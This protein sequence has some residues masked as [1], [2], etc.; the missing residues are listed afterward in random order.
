M[1]IIK[2][3]KEGDNNPVTPMCP[4]SFSNCP[5]LTVIFYLCLPAF[6]WEMKVK[7][8]RTKRTKMLQGLASRKNW[9]AS[10][11]APFRYS[12]L[13]FLSPRLLPT[14]C[15]GP[16][17]CLP[18][19]PQRKWSLYFFPASKQGNGNS[20]ECTDLLQQVC[21]TSENVCTYFY[22]CFF[23]NTGECRSSSLIL[24]GA[25]YLWKVKN[26]CL[27]MS[28]KDSRHTFSLPFLSLFFTSQFDTCHHLRD[29]FPD[30]PAN[31]WFLLCFLAAFE[32]NYFCVYHIQS[33]SHSLNKYILG[34]FYVCTRH[35]TTLI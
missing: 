13:F 23:F 19:R 33:R 12:T 35:Y 30:H 11:R 3:H 21:E 8:L 26:L 25:Y 32:T 27:C 31:N 29:A 14:F 5:C 20:R 7:F 15:W 24:T 1:K 16:W 17:E 34:T 22:I 10:E 9:D 6:C 2:H 18:G 4:L 28:W